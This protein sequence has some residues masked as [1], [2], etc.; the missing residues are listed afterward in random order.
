[1]S[2]IIP[3]ADVDP[4][5]IEQLL[6]S[7][8]EPARHTRTAYKVREGTEWLPGLSFAA[9]D[10]DEMLAG[11]IQCWP[12]ALTDSAGR[13]HPMIMVGPVA[14]LPDLQGKGYGKALM[15]A[16]LTAIDPRAPLPQ[17]L[18]G[19]PEYYERFFGFSNAFTGGW[20]L[21]GPFEQRRLLCRT[22]NP[23]VLPQDGMLGPWRG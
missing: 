9:L 1:M 5:L 15:S 18:I 8:F 22:A 21:P 3:L 20:S 11:T 14:V 12:V 6:D 10:E 4:A 23:A 16:A 17:V 13:K 2:T 7:A 19:D